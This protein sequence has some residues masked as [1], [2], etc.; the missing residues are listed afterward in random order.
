MLAIALATRGRPDVLVDTI[1]ATLKNV[2]NPST[3]FYV[4]VDDDDQETI[5]V[6]SA[7]EDIGDVTISVAPRE[8]S[9]GAKYNRI[10]RLN[11]HADAYLAMVDYAPHITPGFDQKLLDAVQLFP[12][13][14]G[15]VYGPL[16]CTS[17]P[18]INCI[19]RRMCELMDGMYPEWFPY[20]LVDL[21]LDDIAQGIGRVAYAPVEIDRSR[22]RPTSGWRDPAFWTTYYD[23]LWP[24][25]EKL[26]RKLIREMHAPEWHKCLLL[27]RMPHWQQR[28]ILYND[29]CRWQKTRNDYKDD[30]RYQRIKGEAIAKGAREVGAP[31]QRQLIV[32][33]GMVSG[34]MTHVRTRHCLAMMKD[35]TIQHRGDIILGEMPA[36][37]SV[38]TQNQ[39]TIFKAAVEEQMDYLLLVDSDMIFPPDTLV[40]LLSHQTDIV[41]AI[42]RSRQPPFTFVGRPLDA[43]VNLATVQGLV[44]CDHLPSGLILIRCDIL[45]EMGYPWSEEVYDM[46]RWHAT[47]TLVTAAHD[48]LQSGGFAALEAAVREY[49]G[50]PAPTHADSYVMH[51]VHFCRKARAMGYKVYADI[52][53]S[54]KVGHLATI[55]LTLDTEFATRPAA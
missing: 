47:K 16:V 29:L 19:S 39:N 44:E 21:W 24:E 18:A 5:D 43:A 9:L 27:N 23:D 28:S 4:A 48:A 1:R 51:D 10:Y 8:D 34:D 31:A 38:I 14:I 15:V 2:A 45:R 30:E 50:L 35:Y 55:P 13:G 3:R 52:E 37:G 22:R 26:I 53:L 36:M 32:G 46:P 11:P 42:Y 20:S 25:R 7:A 49:D 41:G 54:M 17:L 40:R 6:L 12:D 33:I